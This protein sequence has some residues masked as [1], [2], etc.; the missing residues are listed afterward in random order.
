LSEHAAPDLIRLALDIADAALADRLAELLAGVPGLRL[1]GAGEAADA[2]LVL[3]APAASPADGDDVPLTQ[4]ELEVLALLAE[5]ASN[6]AI[7]R[8]L[9][10]SVHTAK[11][12][13][14]SLLDKL[15][16]IGRTDAVTHAARL[17]V[18]NL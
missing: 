18:I 8:R 13:V 6:K 15:D 12:H 14:G 5:G 17:G 3:P 16:A 7:A 4:R 1:V 9:G 11:F 10:I 2:V